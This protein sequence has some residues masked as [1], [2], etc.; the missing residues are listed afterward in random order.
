[1]LKKLLGSVALVT[2]FLLCTHAEAGAVGG[3]KQA[4][5]KVDAHDSDA[6]VFRLRGGEFAS[7]RVSGDG[8][9]DLDC[10]LYDESEIEVD[11][12]DDTTD[13]CILTVTPRWTGAFRLVILNRGSIYNEYRVQTN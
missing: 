6:Y 2:T 12:D 8:D 5:S 9:T 10:Y 1:V 11:K 13:E 4:H 3:P 7:I